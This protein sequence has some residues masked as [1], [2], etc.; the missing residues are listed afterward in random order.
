MALMLQL[1][2]VSNTHDTN[3][4]KNCVNGDFQAVPSASNV[5]AGTD[6]LKGHLPNWQWQLGSHDASH[7]LQPWYYSTS[8]ETLMA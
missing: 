5:F 2:A 3:S 7:R 1:Q 6:S 8:T 4:G